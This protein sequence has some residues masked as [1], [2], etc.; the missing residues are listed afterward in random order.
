[1]KKLILRY[2]V[3]IIGHLLSMQVISA[4]DQGVLVE[5]RFESSRYRNNESLI[6]TATQSKYVTSPIDSAIKTTSGNITNKDIKSIQIGSNIEKSELYMTSTNNFGSIYYPTWQDVSIV[7]DSLPDINWQIVSGSNKM[8]GPYNCEKAEAIFRGTEIVAYFAPE[9]PI[10]FGPWKFKNLPGLIL[11][12]QVKNSPLGEHWY[13]TKI[14][15]PYIISESIAL[16]KKDKKSM[17]FREYIVST[18]KKF[19]DKLTRAMSRLPAGVQVTK[20]AGV[21]TAIEKKYEWE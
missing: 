8:I 6:A 11:E 16:D 21:R 7:I 5:F 18:E 17:T 19:T 2:L 12:V 13:A 1:M 20:S 3:L 14:V 4:Q 15:Y 9:V 10:N